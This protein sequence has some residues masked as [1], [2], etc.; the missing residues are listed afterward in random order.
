M[1]C[2]CHLLC[3]FLIQPSLSGNTSIY[4]SKNLISRNG[5]YLKIT[6]KE[7]T[8][9][10]QLT[11]NQTHHCCFHRYCHYCC[12]YKPLVSMGPQELMK[13]ACLLRYNCQLWC[14]FQPHSNLPQLLSQFLLF[15]LK[16]NSIRMGKISTFNNV[17]TSNFTK[18][19]ACTNFLLLG[20]KTDR[21]STFFLH[22]TF[23]WVR[24]ATVL[25]WL[26][27]VY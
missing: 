6:Q 15:H 10:K 19:S 9:L 16:K 20:N 11:W 21:C 8:N 14:F 3:I 23:Q 27:C 12:Y 22:H 17:C 4:F 5:S 26:N 2:I 25:S 7:T 13:I 1:S 18:S 24:C